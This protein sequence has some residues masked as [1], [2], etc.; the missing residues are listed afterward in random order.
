MDHR[1]KP[2]GGYLLAMLGRAGVVLATTGVAALTFGLVKGS[3]WGWGSHATAWAPAA[4]AAL[5]AL[6]VLHC[7]RSRTPL[8]QPSLF[9]SRSFTAASL[10][11][12]FFSASFGAMLLSIVLW[13]QGAWGW[14]AL[15]SG[16]ANAPGPIL[17]PF[18]SLVVAGRLIAHYGPSRTMALGSLVFGVGVSWWALAITVRPDYLSGRARGSARHRGRSRPRSTR[19]LRHGWWASAAISVVGIVPALSLLPRPAPA[20]ATTTT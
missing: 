10:V 19:R 6:F 1:R 2:N 15:R 20:T 18:M 14:S 16:L 5:I 13:E 8:I 9:R 4:S 7:L 11:A 17:V 3:D 12:I